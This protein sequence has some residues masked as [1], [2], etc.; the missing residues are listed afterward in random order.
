MVP[1]MWRSP[2]FSRFPRRV[3]V[4]SH[5]MMDGHWS[6][7]VI[8]WLAS[9]EV[10]RCWV[11]SGLRRMTSS[12]SPN[13]GT[14]DL[15]SDVDGAGCNSIEAGAVHAGDAQRAGGFVLSDGDGGVVD[16]LGG[17]EAAE[18]VTGIAVEG[19]YQGQV[20]EVGGGP[21]GEPSDQL[22]LAE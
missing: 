2:R 11:P 6:R 9:A 16:D 20:G 7:R 5:S 8:S 13:G 18:Q 4:W 1:S 21:S 14:G 12:A 17:G 10:M 22:V 3:S 19:A 15:E